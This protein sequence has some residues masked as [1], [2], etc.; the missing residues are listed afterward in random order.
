[1]IQRT[2]VNKRK[3]KVSACIITYNHESFVAKCLEAA[4]NQKLDYDYE[5]VIGEDRS[6]DNTLLI[7]RKYQKK[8]PN[9]IRIVERPENLGMLQNWMGTLEECKGD[10]IAICEADDFWTDSLKL[11]KQVNFLE[12]N[13]EYVLVASKVRT[14]NEKG[15]TEHSEGK[16]YGEIS[17]D[18]ILKRNQITTCTTLFRS[19]FLQIPPFSNTFQFFT[20][21]W[22]LWCS[23][24]QHGKAYNFKEITAQ[25][26]IHSGGAVSGRKRVN[27]LKNKLED[28][29]LM[30]EN[31]P[32]KKKLIKA[33]GMK[34]IFHYFYKSFLMNKEYFR[35]LFLNR[36][37]VVNFLFS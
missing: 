16:I 1:M 26:H 32:K 24:V 12:G 25:Y 15:Q 29:M 27:T 35:A 14:L 20:G 34:I 36:K 3:P 28:R 18:Q 31:F 7:C 19:E 4:V 9:L 10:Y 22:P 8:Y 33:Y 17:L 5:I 11:Q 2:S 23:L 6:T 13:S 21:D 37:V 30:M